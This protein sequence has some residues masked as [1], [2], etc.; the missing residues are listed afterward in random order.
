M[1]TD[2]AS[3]PYAPNEILDHAP[4]RRAFAPLTI[5]GQSPTRSAATTRVPAS[6]ISSKPARIAIM[7]RPSNTSISVPSRSRFAPSADPELAR[8]PTPFSIQTRTSA[9]SVLA[10]SSRAVFRTIPATARITIA[11]AMEGVKPGFPI[12]LA[13]VAPAPGATPVWLFCPPKPFSRL[14]KLTV[15]SGTSVIERRLLPLLSTIQILETPS[16]N[17]LH[18]FSA[19][20]C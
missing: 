20:C 11:T 2:A 14:P 10:A 1:R 6:P 13:R 19:R 12:D 9:C 17:G 3:A 4:P 7:P 5:R 15:S 18:C 8:H 16:G